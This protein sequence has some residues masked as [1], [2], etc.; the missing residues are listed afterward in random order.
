[1]DKLIKVV[2]EKKGM[3]QITTLDE[4]WYG[5]E[6][7][8][9]A[10]LPIWEYDPSLTW[11]CSYYPK[12]KEYLK[13]IAK[14]GWDEAEIIKH[15]AGSRGTIV[16][17]G[18]EKLM[19]ERELAMDALIKD[20]DGVERQMTPDEY[21]CILTASQWYESVGSPK[22]LL[23]EQS[24]RSK[25]LGFSATLD[26]VF[27]MPDKT[28]LL[29]DL[30]TSKNI[31]PSHRIQVIGLNQVCKE[32]DIRVDRMALLQVGYTANKTQHYKLTEVEDKP[33]LLMAAR[34]FWANEND[35]SVPFQ[36]DYPLVIK[37]A[38]VS[39]EASATAKAPATAP[40]K[41]AKK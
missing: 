36:R 3:I 15:E 20:R 19:I 26:Y 29:L 12:G 37:L 24:L 32:N 9:D 38:P 2:D 34:E 40:R 10:G 21:Y 35:G 6:S 30:K 22:P 14:N 5:V 28:N 17:H 18:F 4:R 11:I 13:W 1:M 16:H 39:T 25:K 8:N 33:R 23:I 27:E 7:K 31:W 41:P